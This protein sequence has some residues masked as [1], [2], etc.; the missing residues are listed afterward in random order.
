MNLVSGLK[1]IRNVLISF[2]YS[3][4]YSFGRNPHFGR[5][6]VLIGKDINVGD[7]FYMGRYSS[8]ECDLEG[9]HDI[10]ISNYVAFIGKYDHEIGQIGVPMRLSHHVWDDDFN[11]DKY[12]SNRVIIGNDVWIGWNSIILSG[13]KIGD[14][15]IV[16]AGSV[17]T[18]DVPDFS[19]VGGVPARKLSNRFKSDKDKKMHISKYRELLRNRVN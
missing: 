1:M 12:G 16:A 8:I 19:I 9:G 17:V 10:L 14:G 13:V 3:F 6:I 15:A 4:R 2:K 11:R 7:N 5:R 18:K